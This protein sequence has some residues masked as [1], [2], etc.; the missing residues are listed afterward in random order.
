MTAPIKSFKTRCTFRK[1]IVL[2]SCSNFMLT[3]QIN[4]SF[5]LQIKQAQILSVTVTCTLAFVIHNK[6]RE[7]AG[8]HSRRDTNT[9][10]S[11][12][13][14]VGKYSRQDGKYRF[15]ASKRK[16]GDFNKEEEQVGREM[17]RLDKA[18]TNW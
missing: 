16:G 11:L 4:H 7:Q 13:D 8:K 6:T 12:R 5:A 9:G 15:Q 14:T 10:M 17:V 3:L 2:F 18:Q 1:L